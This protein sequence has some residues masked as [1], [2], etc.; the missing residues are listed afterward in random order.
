METISYLVWH[1]FLP[2]GFR[3]SY[4]ITLP[5]YVVSIDCG[6]KSSD[7]IRKDS[8]VHVSKQRHREAG[9]E[10]KYGSQI[11]LLHPAIVLAQH[12]QPEDQLAIS[13]GQVEAY[14]SEILHVQI[15]PSYPSHFYLFLPTFFLVLFPNNRPL[16]S[17]TL[18]GLGPS[19]GAC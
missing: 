16:L 3:L 19:A 17:T 7:R 12:Q 8:K 14:Q 10:G 2:L 5:L 4:H 13:S 18:G 6:L 9:R 1:L 11:V 15:H